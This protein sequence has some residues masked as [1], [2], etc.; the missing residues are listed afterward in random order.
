MRKLADKHGLGKIVELL[1]TIDIKK[2][3]VYHAVSGRSM[4]KINDLPKWASALGLKNWRAFFK[5]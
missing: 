2:P 1:D 4:P 5:S 3:S